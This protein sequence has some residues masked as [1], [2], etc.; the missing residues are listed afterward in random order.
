MVPLFI[1]LSTCC[2]DAISLVSCCVF[3]TS[4]NFWSLVL[5]FCGSQQT[6]QKSTNVAAFS[7]TKTP[8]L[9]LSMKVI[10][11]K[12]S[13]NS[14]LRICTCSSRSWRQGHNLYY[15][16]T[17]NTCCTF[18]PKKKA[19]IWGERR[20][21]KKQYR[22]H[23]YSKFEIIWA[24]GATNP[25]SSTIQYANV[26]LLLQFS[27]MSSLCYHYVRNHFFVMSRQWNQ[28]WTQS[29]RLFTQFLFAAWSSLVYNP[30]VCGHLYQPCA[31][32]R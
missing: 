32:P 20:K 2:C 25:E 5:R 6:W 7:Y 24:L 31:F 1:N 26:G 21:G 17:P 9:R 30:C 23:I 22:E 19:E 28:I 16:F 18:F 10:H 15:K 27:G 3:I 8:Y 13:T 14:A 12:T 29:S 11:T 4:W